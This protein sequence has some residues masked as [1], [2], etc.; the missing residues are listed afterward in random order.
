MSFRGASDREV[1]GLFAG[2]GGIEVGL[3]RGGYATALIC[4]NAP[5]AQ[6]VL[7]ARFP[8]VPLADDVRTLKAIPRA[9]IVAAEALPV[10]GPQP[11]G[12]NGWD[13][14]APIQLVAEVF[15][16][17]REGEPAGSSSKTYRSCSSSEAAPCTRPDRRHAR[18][19]RLSLGVPRRRRLAFGL[20]QRRKRVFL[21]AS[22]TNPREVLFADEAGEPARATHAERCGFYWTEGIRGLGW[23][24]DAVPT[25]KGGST[26][27]IPS[28]PAIWMPDGSVV[29][30]TSASERCRG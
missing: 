21:V 4:E 27:G 5:A 26:V 10:S 30:P 8:G 2:I 25:L 20:P 15:R 14:G 19:P 13:R 1:V 17:L 24:V 28:P 12:Q 11:G 16:L 6:H 22:G 23:A 29:T 7:R 18:R 9:T 3:H